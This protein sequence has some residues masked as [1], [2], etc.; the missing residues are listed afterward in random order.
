MSVALR[1]PN[2]TNV[3]WLLNV[4]YFRAKAISSE[5]C[6]PPHPTAGGEIARNGVKIKDHGGVNDDREESVKS[7]MRDLEGEGELK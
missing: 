7:P 2:R 6:P 4:R 3:D 1:R 5:E